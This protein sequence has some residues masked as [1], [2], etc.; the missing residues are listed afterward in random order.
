M[1]LE[2]NDDELER[3]AYDPQAHTTRWGPDVTKAFQRVLFYIANAEDERDIRASKGL[4]LEK[5]KGKRAGT[6]SV[7]INSKYRLILRFE[8]SA[9][10]K[11][12]V[13]IEAV[14][15]H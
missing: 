8:T 3:L 10:T 12:A 5:L 13:V 15:Y 11:V 6:W 9:D 4:R 1:Q 7:R 2:F 14:D